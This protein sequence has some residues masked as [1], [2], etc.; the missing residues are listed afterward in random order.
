MSSFQTVKAQP[1]VLDNL[2]AFRD[3]LLHTGMVGELDHNTGRLVALVFHLQQYFP[4]MVDF[5]VHA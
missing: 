4:P 1:H 5:P 3:R 2:K